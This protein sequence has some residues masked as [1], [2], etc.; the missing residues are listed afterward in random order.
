M[1]VTIPS[2]ALQAVVVG[3]SDGVLYWLDIASCIGWKLPQ[4]GSKQW[5]TWQAL[6]G[7]QQWQT[8]GLG[9]CLDGLP[10]QTSTCLLQSG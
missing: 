3:C 10:W 8:A 4:V 2:G 6:S 5:W 7:L 1:T 9:L